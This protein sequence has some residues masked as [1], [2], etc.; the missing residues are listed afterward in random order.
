MNQ[1]WKEAAKAV[2]EGKGKTGWSL[3][4]PNMSNSSFGPRW[5]LPFASAGWHSSSFPQLFVPSFYNILLNI[6]SLPLRA[7]PIS[8]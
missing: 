7:F 2:E 5:H 4:W 8:K 3:L 1:Q 6:S